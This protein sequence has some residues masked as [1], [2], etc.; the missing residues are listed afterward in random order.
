MKRKTIFILMLI[1]CLLCGAL[2]QAAPA[3]AE[4]VEAAATDKET[5]R[6]AQKQLI[7]LGLLK[8]KAD[9]V[10]GPKTQAAVKAF[11]A[12]RGLGETG[13]LDADTLAALRGAT[14]E[15]EAEDAPG[16]TAAPSAKAS[17]T[18]EKVQ[19]RL[20]DLGYLTGKADG[21]WGA[22]STAAMKQFQRLHGLTAT[23]KAD[24]D[25][26]NQ[27]F[28]DDAKAL[29]ATLR[30]GDS[31]D[32]VAA[33][34]AVLC[35]MGF[36]AED[37][38]GSFGRET[39]EAVKAFQQ[40]LI[41]QDLGERFDIA[42]TGEADPM[43]L[44]II[45]NPA[46][47]DYLRD[48]AAGEQSDE[49]LRVKRRLAY[50]GYM[51]LA[52]DDVMD[53]YGMA[54]LELFKARAGVLTFGGADRSTQDMLF[55]TDAPVATRCAY[56]DIASGDSGV[57]V[58]AAERALIDG[59][60]MLKVANGSYDKDMEKGV[61]RLYQY[62]QAQGDAKAE[63]FSNAQALSAG[64]VEALADGDLLGYVSDVGSGSKKEAEIARVQRRLYALYYL[65]KSGID[66]RF[67]GESKDA[68]KAFQS[69][70]GLK[71]SG[72]AD[73]AT[74]EIL[75]S[76][77]ATAKPYPWRVNVNIKDQR[78]RVY[79]LNDQGEY[80]QEQEFI[81]STGLND[82]TPRGI[83]LEGHPISRWHYFDKFN[84]WA[85]YS[86]EIEG[87]IMFHS[88]IYGS[89]NENSLRTSSV[90]NLGRPASHGCVR[91]KVAD[92]KWLFENC[93]RGT[94]VIVVE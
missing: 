19:Q 45:M 30:T 31:G 93:K 46:Y 68:V 10:A 33:L 61:E 89:K 80:V 51:D 75:F 11:Q 59:G 64:A 92:A 7:A 48:V 82:A 27:L 60:M 47:S 41:D 1:A 18:P 34:Q 94:V 28:A 36:L 37:G 4:S 90:N 83:F 2:A 17:A 69:A 72:T 24:R 67:G 77:D 88:V 55:S 23:G 49:A 50:L 65:S 40:H 52:A 81:C 8:G 15:A 70:N 9:G 76:E 86:F 56:H 54:A 63:L 53:E 5:V 91:L 26:V 38:D 12:Q 21:I 79:S 14:P 78:V 13:V 16:Q 66:G 35:R 29:P 42:V 74:Q 71:A 87:E 85:Q 73:R 39:A 62:L 3:R 25:S 32:E 57:V 22:K 84:C 20:I 58:S 44:Y 6:Q 43:T